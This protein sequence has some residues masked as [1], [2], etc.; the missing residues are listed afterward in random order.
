MQHNPR[1]KLIDV[2]GANNLHELYCQNCSIES[3][4]LNQNPVLSLLLC[5]GNRL[6]SLDLSANQQLL[7]LGC[8]Y[9]SLDKEALETIYRQLPDVTNDIEDLELRMH[10]HPELFR[11]LRADHN[12]GYSEANQTIAIRKGWEFEDKSIAG[13]PILRLS[14]Y[15]GQR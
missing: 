2:S 13:S 6:T 4:N 3:L 14:V 15:G 12:P 5:D 1:L 10:H 11:M 7:A 9:N 8:N